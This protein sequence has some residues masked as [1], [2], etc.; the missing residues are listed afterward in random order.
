MKSDQLMYT[1]EGNPD[2]K[3]LVFL[4]G[5]PDDPSLWRQQLSAVEKQ[6]RCVLITLP[7]FGDTIHQPRGC[8]LTEWVARLA[9]TVEQVQP[10]EPVWL[11]GHDWGAHLAYLF[12]QEYPEFHRLSHKHIKHLLRLFAFPD[13]PNVELQ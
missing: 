12:E 10:N 9:K 11:V 8:S 13:L 4:H 6:Y 1:I 7:N 5:W 3:T 2:G